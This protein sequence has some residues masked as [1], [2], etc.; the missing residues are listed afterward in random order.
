MSY[1]WKVEG[2]SYLCLAVMEKMLLQSVSHLQDCDLSCELSHCTT[3]HCHIQNVQ[4]RKRVIHSFEPNPSQ[5]FA[6]ADSF[7]LLYRCLACPPLHS[8]PCPL[9]RFNCC[10]ALFYTFSFTHSFAQVC[11]HKLS[12]NPVS[13]MR[14]I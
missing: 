1:S 5:S 11:S 13:L 3:K 12:R 4:N 8:H 7:Q 6:S 14:D 9:T 2:K 10:I